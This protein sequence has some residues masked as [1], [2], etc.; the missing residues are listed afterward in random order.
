MTA[1]ILIYI[2]HQDDTE[3]TDMSIEP[4]EEFSVIKVPML[5]LLALTAVGC[6]RFTKLMPS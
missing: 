6:P 1:Q 5:E 4:N 2:R 3:A